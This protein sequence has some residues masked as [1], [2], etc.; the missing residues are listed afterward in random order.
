LIIL[1]FPRGLDIPTVDLVLNE[2]VPMVPKEYVHRVGRT[3]RAGLSS[4]II[5]NNPNK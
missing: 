3:A 2:N 4:E 5:L 1:F